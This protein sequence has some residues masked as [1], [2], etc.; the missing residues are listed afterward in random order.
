MPGLLELLGQTWPAR[1]AQSAWSAAKLPGDVYAGRVDPLSEEGIGR[2][3][4]LAGMVTG[5][6]TFARP[7]PI[8]ATP[9][10]LPAPSIRAYHGSPHDFERFDLSK[11]GAGEGNQAWGHGIYV[12]ENPKVSAEYRPPGGRS[13][14]VNVRADPEHFYS[15]DL[16]PEQQGQVVRDALA[17]TGID[18]AEKLAVAADDP[19]AIAK[20][21]DAGV[22]G[23]KYLDKGSRAA[24]KGTHNYV[25]F[26]DDIIDIVKKYG[27]A[28]LGLFG[29]GK[30][31]AKAAGVEP[32]KTRIGNKSYG[33]D[34]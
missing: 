21:R 13:Y 11:I 23:F 18:T 20:L 26:R 15:W 10:P 14:E 7:R 25:L 31:E 17:K 2:A 4:D 9:P 3:T 30:D 34:E 19:A 8:P 12:A 16:P 24:G 1:L 33:D 32:G 27:W 22:A 28:G 5:G 29:I 6:S